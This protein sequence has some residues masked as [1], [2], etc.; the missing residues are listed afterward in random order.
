MLSK[1]MIPKFRKNLLLAIL[2]Q[3][4]RKMLH[5]GGA[6][7][8]ELKVIKQSDATLHQRLALSDGQI[9]FQS[10]PTGQIDAE[11]FDGFVTFGLNLNK[12]N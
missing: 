1:P 10:I 8:A 7:K 9:T 12:H 5:Q 11:F 4:R 2:A 6:D 3:Y